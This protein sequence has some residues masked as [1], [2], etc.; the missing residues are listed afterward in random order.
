MGINPVS[1]KSKIK[2]FA[3]CLVAA[4]FFWLMNALNKDN[5]SLKLSYPIRF[6][7]D[8]SAYVPVQTLPNQVSVN[9]S[10]DGWRLLRK[11]WLSFNAPPLSYTVQNP[12]TATSIN[13]TSLTDQI[14]EH[15][16][17]IKVNYVV[18]DTLELAFEKKSSKIISIRIDSAGIDLRDGFVVSSL[19]NVSPSLITVEG[20]ASLIRHYPDT[21]YVRIPGTKIQNNFDDYATIPLPDIPLVQQS[22]RSVFVSFEVARL[23][24]PLV[25]PPVQ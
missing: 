13:T 1:N 5:Y 15:F 9:V 19:I 2:T 20:P 4:A 17:D 21:L 7:Y 23:L 3:V 24:R 18:A 6:V 25:L 16:P 10:G 12:L 22:H 14:M 11:S 8:D